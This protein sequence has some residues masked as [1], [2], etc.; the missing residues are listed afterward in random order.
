MGKQPDSRPP[1]HHGN[2]TQG[3]E[4]EVLKGG[5]RTLE[6]ASVLKTEVAFPPLERHGCSEAGLHTALRA[7]G[8][9]FVVPATNSCKVCP[10]YDLVGRRHA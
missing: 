8:F 5:P 2:S 1:P 3:F 10:F 7:R 9:D 6:R 4:C